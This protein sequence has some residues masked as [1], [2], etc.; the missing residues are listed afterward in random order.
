MFLFFHQTKLV[1]ELGG[2]GGGRE[3]SR[4][5]FFRVIVCWLLIRTLESVT[6]RLKGFTAIALIRS[7]KL[8]NNNDHKQASLA[9]YNS[10]DL[11]HFLLLP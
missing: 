3:R 2:G 1:T 10:N 7:I 9:N 8:A 4:R 11:L 5:D 6:F